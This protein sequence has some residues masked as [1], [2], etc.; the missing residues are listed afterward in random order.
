ME[1]K[2]HVYAVSG[3]L[4][5]FGSNMENWEEWFDVEKE[6]LR[7]TLFFPA[8]GNHDISDAHLFEEF[9]RVTDKSPLLASNI[10]GLPLIA[11]DTTVKFEDENDPQLQFL[12]EF[13][14]KLK[15]VRPIIIVHHP[16]FNNGKHWA[17][18]NV[19]DLLVPF[20]VKHKIPMMISGHDHNYQRFNKK[21]GTQYVISGGGGAPLYKIDTFEGLAAGA[22]V[23]HFIIGIFQNNKL[24][25]NVVNQDLSTIDRFNVSLIPK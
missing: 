8:I 22:V 6:L 2:P 21:N 3:D 13:V 7:T 4:V 1:I 11:L 19:R 16:P 24:Q 5:G 10:G 20:I 14:E 15:P 9:F 17:V 12:K 25:L 18:D 23:P